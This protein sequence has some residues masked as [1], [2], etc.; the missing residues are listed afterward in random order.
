[1]KNVKK[2]LKRRDDKIE[3]LQL[4]SE[5]LRHEISEQQKLV[6]HYENENCL[7]QERNS[8]LHNKRE[9]ARIKSYRVSK[10][11]EEKCES[12]EWTSF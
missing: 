12:A 9:K 6:K 8:L 5:A 1:M 11:A 3:D 10:N 4:Q 2:R 7:L